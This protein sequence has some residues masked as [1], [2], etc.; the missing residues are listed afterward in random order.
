MT[1][2]KSDTLDSRIAEA[3]TGN[4]VAWLERQVA[5][6]HGVFVVGNLIEHWRVQLSC[7]D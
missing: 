6:H 1:K 5:E 3:L 4:P 7:D 2:P